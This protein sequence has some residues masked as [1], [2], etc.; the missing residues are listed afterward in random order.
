MSPRG[1]P[2]GGKHRGFEGT[3][4]SKVVSVLNPNPRAHLNHDILYCF[5]IYIYILSYYIMLLP[6]EKK[7]LGNAC[8]AEQNQADTGRAVRRYEA[9]I[10]APTLPAPAASLSA[11]TSLFSQTCV[12]TCF[13]PDLLW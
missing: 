8:L 11:E 7:Q 10:K 1:P 5:I 12:Q 3:S 4:P 6:Q 2:K 13:G 9:G